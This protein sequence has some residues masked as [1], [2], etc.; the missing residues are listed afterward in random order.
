[1]P[2]Q[3][4]V[5]DI[6]AKHNVSIEELTALSLILSNHYPF[7]KL[8]SLLKAQVEVMEE[9]LRRRNDPSSIRTN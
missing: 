4:Y 3:Q 7:L 6:C 1:M 2:V 8:I 5:K 9:V